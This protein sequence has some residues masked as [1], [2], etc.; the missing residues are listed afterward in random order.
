[1]LIK[2]TSNCIFYLVKPGFD[3]MRKLE[4]SLASLKRHLPATLL[5]ADLIL[6]IEGDA[7][8]YIDLVDQLDLKAKLVEMPVSAELARLD[9]RL[10]P[11]IYPHPNS[12]IWK[13]KENAEGFSLGYRYMC[14]LYSGALYEHP[15]LA[16]YEYCLR[17]DCDSEF[18]A[19]TKESLFSYAT[20]RNYEYVTLAGG[21]QYD[22]E[23]V[24]LGLQ[25]TARRHFKRNGNLINKIRFWIF[26]RK[27]AM[28]YTNIELGKLSFF[29]SQAYKGL[30]DSLDEADG[31]Y[32]LRWGDAVVKYIAVRTLLPRR[33]WGYF[34]DI[35]YTHGAAYESVGGSLM[36]TKI[37][38][39][40]IL[41]CLPRGLHRLLHPHTGR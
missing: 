18:T 37:L 13:Q 14:R 35:S 15:V 34:W 17:L 6:G 1:M 21:L 22:H 7:A 36:K 16:G 24:T 23:L 33:K 40:E 3:E 41:H 5:D 10:V 11:E 26:V 31:F 32:R 20:E 28:F 12:N 25:E 4:T 38:A 27:D 9:R 29:R 30:F 8:H 19:P 39:L 2:P